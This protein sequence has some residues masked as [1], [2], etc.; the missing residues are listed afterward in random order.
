VS[1]GIERTLKNVRD[2]IF[3][4]R[5]DDMSLCRHIALWRERKL[6]RGLQRFRIY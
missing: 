5:S 1:K 6:S 2:L 3:D 4:N